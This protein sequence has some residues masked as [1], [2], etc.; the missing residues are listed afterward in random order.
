MLRNKKRE[1]KIKQYIEKK[2]Q[3]DWTVITRY[4]I[5]SPVCYKLIN[6]NNNNNNNNNNIIIININYN[7]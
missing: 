3:D 1:K 4:N 2:C 6:S 7:L 5:D